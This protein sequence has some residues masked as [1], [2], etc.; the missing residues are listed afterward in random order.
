V[1]PWS[2]STAA[3]TSHVSAEPLSAS[4]V[5]DAFDAPRWARYTPATD[6]ADEGRL[7]GAECQVRFDWPSQQGGPRVV[8]VAVL[9]LAG[10]GVCST[11][12][13][14]ILTSVPGHV[15]AFGRS[16]HSPATRTMKYNELYLL[17]LIC[18]IFGGTT[19]SGYIPTAVAFVLALL[20]GTG[21]F[22]IGTHIHNRRV[23]TKFVSD[24]NPPQQSQ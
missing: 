4:P 10:S 22:F 23:E 13:T 5:A 8:I 24:I 19:L 9:L 20:C 15:P 14:R 7:G 11:I 21:P 17:S 16:R 3:S 6:H 18:L 1:P 12:C 2:L